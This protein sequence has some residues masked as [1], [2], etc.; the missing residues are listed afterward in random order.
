MAHWLLKS[1]PDTYGWRDLLAE[2]ETEWTGVRNPAAAL[3]LKAM[4]MGDQAF[5]YHSG[6]TREIIGTVEIVRAA[7][8]DGDEARWVSVA[9]RPLAA[10]AAP[11]TLATIKATP[12]LAGL[13]MLRQSRLS[14]SPVGETEWAAIVALGSPA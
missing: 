11:V 4:R 5:F 12:A 2:G 8:Q 3:H 1:E 9:V 7:R 14:V 6:K 13:E 10:F